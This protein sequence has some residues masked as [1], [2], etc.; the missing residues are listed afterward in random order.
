[1]EQMALKFMLHHNR[2]VWIWTRI[3]L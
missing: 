3:H 2:G 1:M